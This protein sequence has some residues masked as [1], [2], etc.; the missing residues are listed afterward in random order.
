LAT[1]AHAEQQLLFLEWNSFP[2]PNLQQ[3]CLTPTVQVELNNCR[4]GLSISF[5]FER[6]NYIFLKM[7]QVKFQV[8]SIFV[9]NTANK[10]FLNSVAHHEQVKYYMGQCEKSFVQQLPEQHLQLELNCY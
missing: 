1:A 5:V 2:L 8:K 4:R 9:S 3:I 7:T 6:T 10:Y